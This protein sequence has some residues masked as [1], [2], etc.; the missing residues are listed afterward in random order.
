MRVIG[1]TTNGMVKESIPLKTAINTRE[2]SRIM[3]S[4]G[5][6]Y[7]STKKLAA[8]SRLSGTSESCKAV[9]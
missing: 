8:H 2:G 4:M 5:L 1:N 6:G 9:G 3:C 7:V